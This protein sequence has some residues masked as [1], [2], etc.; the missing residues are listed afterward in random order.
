M[1]PSIDRTNFDKHWLE[2]SVSNREGRFNKFRLKEKENS[3][4]LIKNSLSEAVL[5]HHMEPDEIQICLDLLEYNEL[6]KEIAKRLPSRTIERKDDKTQRNTVRIG[7]FGEIVAAEHLCQCYGYSIPIFKLR[8][9]VSNEIAMPGEDIVLFTISDDEQIESILFGEV[10]T[11][12]KYNGNKVVEAHDRLNKI[13]EID[14]VTL[15]FISRSLIKEKNPL[16][17]QIMKILNIIGLNDFPTENWIFIITGN[18]PIDPFRRIFEMQD[19][20]KNLSVISLH[21]PDLPDF[22][23]EIFDLATKIPRC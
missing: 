3:R 13:Y 11:L 1:T 10:K 15:Y 6:T 4:D 8:Y 16:G 17:K 22:I 14:P 21:L 12:K 18:E 7:N 5:L 19:V 20:A 2:Y 23:D 9:A